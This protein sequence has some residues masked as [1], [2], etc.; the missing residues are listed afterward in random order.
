MMGL[1][2]KETSEV[3]ERV[4]REFY[5]PAM[6]DEV[7]QKAVDQ[8]VADLENIVGMRVRMEVQR[9]LTLVETPGNLAAEA[10]VWA[11]LALAAVGANDY[12]LARAYR[13]KTTDLLGR[14][15]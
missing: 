9:L 1:D 5:N 10:Q 2:A 4:V 3:I 8:T 13:E 15:P 11:T 14:M 12:E 7:R 6:I